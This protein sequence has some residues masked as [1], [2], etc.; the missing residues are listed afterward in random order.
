[1]FSDNYIDAVKEQKIEIQVG[2]AKEICST[3]VLLEDG[4]II[5]ADVI[6]LGTG[7]ITS[8][9]FLSE[10][11]K[12]VIKYRENNNFITCSLYRGIVHPDLQRICFMGNQVSQFPGVFELQAEIG[13]RY[14]LDL[15]NVSKE[16]MVEG[17]CYED[18]VR[19]CY[20][21]IYDPYTPLAHLYELIR[22]LNVNINLEFISDVLQ[23]ANG[24]F[25]PQL[26]WIERPGQIDLV[27]KVISD[28][29]EQ[30]P[31][32]FS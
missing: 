22:V 12:N 15:L 5:E 16:E 1:M 19:S 9:S 13:I 31:Q 29:K 28:Y 30:F 26:L 3:G 7:Y 24:P 23:F 32:L 8:Y 4:K 20:P 21:L 18:E 6:V 2:T 11:L 25:L 10:E 27:K 14:L 17:V